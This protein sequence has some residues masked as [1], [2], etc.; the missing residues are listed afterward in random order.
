[1][2]NNWYNFAL[3]EKIRKL[4]RQLTDIAKKRPARPAN[5][6]YL[7]IALWQESGLSQVKFCS[8]EKPEVLNKTGN[9]NQG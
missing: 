3:C 9:E 1:L 7:A 4:V 6:F 5:G 8:R 2:K